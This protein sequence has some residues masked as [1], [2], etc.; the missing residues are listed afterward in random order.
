MITYRYRN[1]HEMQQKDQRQN[2]QTISLMSS[3]S[4][5]SLVSSPAIWRIDSVPV[6]SVVIVLTFEDL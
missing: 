5:S 3:I 1:D 6:Q 2:L 4:L